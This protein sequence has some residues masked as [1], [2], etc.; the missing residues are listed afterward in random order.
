M[1]EKIFERLRYLINDNDGYTHAHVFDIDGTLVD[2]NLLLRTTIALSREVG[3]NPLATMEH[4]DYPAIAYKYWGPN[5][6]SD[7]QK[8]AIKMWDN[9]F[10]SGMHVSQIKELQYLGLPRIIKSCLSFP[11]L[12]ILALRRQKPRPLLIAISGML[13]EIADIVCL[14]LGLDLVIGIDRPKIDGYFT[15]EKPNLDPGMDKGKVMDLLSRECQ[16]NWTDCIALGDTLY[17]LPSFE[18]ARY[19]IA[20]NPKPDLQKKIRSS[21]SETWHAK[22][23]A[24]VDQFAGEKANSCSIWLPNERGKLVSC[25]AENILPHNVLNEMGIGLER[26]NNYAV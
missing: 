2:D 13:Q 14:P 12:L 4:D 23:I 6:A 3:I 7:I 20:I 17:D 26:I 15:D 11:R 1:D 18:R 21:S 16:I 8:I 25:D 10:F 9:N 5:F 22:R 24:W 19:P